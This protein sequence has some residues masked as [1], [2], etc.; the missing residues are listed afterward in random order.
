MKK[1]ANA[2]D[3]DYK[4]FA[5]ERERARFPDIEMFLLFLEFRLPIVCIGIMSKKDT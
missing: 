1:F 4:W 5:D 3:I 2:Y